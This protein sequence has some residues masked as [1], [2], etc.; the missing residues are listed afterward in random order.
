VLF[1]AVALTPVHRVYADANNPDVIPTFID[2]I[3]RG[4]ANLAM[5]LASPNLTL[6]LPG[7]VTVPVNPATPI[8]ATFLPITIVSLTPEGTGTQTVDGVFTLGSDPT[9][10]RVQIRGDGGVIVSIVLLGP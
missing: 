4:D 10:Q 3:N 8:P 9:Q 5:Q 6:T 2:A 7:G 1:A